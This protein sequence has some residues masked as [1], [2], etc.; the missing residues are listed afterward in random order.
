ML[1]AATLFAD[2]K[3]ALEHPSL[4]MLFLLVSYS[5]NKNTRFLAGI[6]AASSGFA[7]DVW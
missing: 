1:D 5:R 3:S 2:E 6:F 7:C 4:G